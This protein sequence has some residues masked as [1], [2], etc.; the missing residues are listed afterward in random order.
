MG[1]KSASLVKVAGVASPAAFAKL[2]VAPGER[3]LVK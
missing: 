1:S 3:G 2:L